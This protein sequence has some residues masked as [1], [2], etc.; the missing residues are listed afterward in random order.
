VLLTGACSDDDDPAA[1]DTSDATE[2]TDAATTDTDAPGTGDGG[3]GTDGTINDTVP[4]GEGA[5]ALPAV[6]F[7]ATADFGGGITARLVGIEATEVEATLPGEV[8][9]P[10]VAIT[11]ELRND[12][13]AAV[14]LSQALVDL[15]ATG[16]RYAPL[17][18]TADDT[19]LAGSLAAGAT[20]EGTY[21]FTIDPADR[22]EVTILVTYAVAEPT[23]TFTG[24]LP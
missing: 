4:E 3:S 18:T 21:L 23:A 10:G 1:A 2:A 13:A 14:D 9:G 5:G 11:A 6:G 22:A 8:S 20:A 19:G 17:I 16:D 7:D 12:S 15:V 24:S